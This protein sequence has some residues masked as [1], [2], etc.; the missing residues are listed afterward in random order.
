[1]LRIVKPLTRAEL[2][3]IIKRINYKHTANLIN[4]CQKGK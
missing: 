2:Q 4:N 3:A 1:M